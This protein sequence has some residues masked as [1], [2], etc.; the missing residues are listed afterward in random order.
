MAS[1]KTIDNP[2]AEAVVQRLNRIEGQ[3]RGIKQ[4]VEEGR[5]CVDILMQ[6]SSVHEALRGVS[7]EM[8]RTYLECCATQGI[9][10]GDPQQ[11]EEVYDALIDLMFKYAK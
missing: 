5:Y 3:V 4:M 8:M 9:R 1:Q 11:A 10:S 2:R 6:I 7:K